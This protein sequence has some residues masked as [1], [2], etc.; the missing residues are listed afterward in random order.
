MFSAT[1]FKVLIATPGDTS[2][3]V[4]AITNNL[5]NWNGHRAEAQ[6]TILLPRHWRSDTVPLLNTDGPQAVINAQIV[7]DADIVVAVFDSRL[8]QATL[9][10]VSGTAYEIE[11]TSTAG[12]PVHVY[13]SD[14]PVDRKAINLEE[15]GRLYEFRRHM[16]SK[17]LVKVYEDPT[18]L[19]YLVREAVEHDM[20]KLALAVTSSAAAVPSQ[21]HAM[22]R[23]RYD[24]SDKCLIAENVSDRVRAEQLTLEI[25]DEAYLIEYDGEP[26]DLA[27]RG[28]RAQWDVVLFAQSPSKV[29]VAVNWLENGEPQS[30]LQT[31]YF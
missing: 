21:E 7:D 9:G 23:L 11:R 14:E 19:G 24:K 28:G 30:D 20:T 22:P 13:F 27:P 18:A 2:E 4:A 25:P 3:E 1:V 12:K 31:V 5:Q 15:L 17:G 16:E 8:G 6:G 10:A 29:K 26:E